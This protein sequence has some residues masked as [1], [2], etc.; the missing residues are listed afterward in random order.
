MVSNGREQVHC[1]GY[2]LAFV[3]PMPGFD[4]ALPLRCEQGKAC[5][6]VRQTGIIERMLRGLMWRLEIEHQAPYGR[7]GTWEESQVIII[8]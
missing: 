5:F 1:V 4:I 3:S 6:L 2:V 7:P 8:R